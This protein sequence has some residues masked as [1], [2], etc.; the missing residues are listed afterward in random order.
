MKKNYF[1]LIIPVILSCNQPKA[2]HR[3]PNELAL[4]KKFGDADSIYKAQINDVAKKE[5]IISSKGQI[6][7]FIEK[8]LNAKAD[9]WEAHVYSIKPGVNGI[10]AV[11]LISKQEEFGDVKYPD[12]ESLVLESEEITD[13]KLTK[14]L[15][16][17]QK[18]DKV[19]LSGKF[20]TRVLDHGKDGIGVVFQTMN[21]V[22]IDSE[23][24]L[25]NPSFNFILTDI[26]KKEVEKP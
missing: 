8:D 15:K 13:T 16:T 1:L 23:D 14:I 6:I 12:M 19:L 3:A 10:D 26:K 9:N 22:T 2:D 18:D 4:I 25:N 5:S 7:D 24:E 20:D 17:L 21:R 11:F